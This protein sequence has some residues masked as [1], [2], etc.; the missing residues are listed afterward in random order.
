[1][2]IEAASDLWGLGEL[3][4]PRFFFD[5]SEEHPDTI[6]VDLPDSRSA[7]AEA[8]RAAGEILK[9][10]DGD[11]SGREWIMTVRDERG[12]FVLEVQ[13]TVIESEAR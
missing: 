2:R 6:G 9:D 11:F 5:V 10:I 13:F 3:A 1:M 7:R 4:L 8:I 12:Q